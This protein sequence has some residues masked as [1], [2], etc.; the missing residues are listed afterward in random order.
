[1]PP[2]LGRHVLLAAAEVVI[3]TEEVGKVAIAM[4]SDSAAI[5]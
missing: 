4:L 3:E 2:D 5:G 1:L